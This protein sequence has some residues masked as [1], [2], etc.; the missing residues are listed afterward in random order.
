[1]T[2]RTTARSIVLL[3]AAMFV[4][5]AIPARAQDDESIVLS[6]KKTRALVHAYA[7]CIVKRQPT[8]AGK[9]I[10]RNLGRG[11]LL[12]LYPE[13]MDAECLKRGAS[14]TMMVRFGGDL[15]QYALADA[16]VRRELATFTGNN[17]DAVPRL[18]H[19]DPGLQPAEVNAKGKKVDAKK[20]EASIKG[21]N[22]AQAFNF[23]SRYGECV[24]RLHP[25]GSQALL[26]TVPDSPEEADRFKTLVPT[27]ARCLPEDQSMSFGRVTLRGTI[28]VNYYRLAMAARAAAAANGTAG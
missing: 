17:F 4:A 7:T 11:M 9:A 23:L 15:Y 25:V 21:Y 6:T 10:V 14:E 28:A 1:M 2:V 12:S 20:L 13:L 16:L 3:V 5:A 22:E 18:E 24:A 27:L 8:K 26:L 19:R